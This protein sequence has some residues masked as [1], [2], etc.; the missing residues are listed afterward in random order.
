M[1]HRRDGVQIIG[2]YRLQKAE[3]SDEMKRLNVKQA[4]LYVGGILVCQLSWMGCFPLI[5]AYYTAVCLEDTARGLLSL[6]MLAGI[7]LFVP[8]TAAVKYLMALMVILI[9]VKLFEWAEGRCTVFCGAIAATMATAMTSVAGALLDMRGQTG[10][11]VSVLESLFVFSVIMAG[12]RFINRFLQLSLFPGHLDAG[13]YKEQ[14]LVNYADSFSGLSKVF[15]RMS[16]IRKELSPE[17]VGR[18]QDELTGSLCINCDQCAICWEKEESTM[19]ACLAYM[20]QSLQRTG[21]PDQEMIVQMQERCPY[22]DA[23]IHEAVRIFEKARLN[24]AWYNR[25]VENRE[26]IAQQLDAMAYIMEDC[27]SEIT[28]ITQENRHLIAEVKFRAKERGVM[29]QKAHLYENKAKRWQFTCQARSR[30][31]GCISM[32]ELTRAVSAGLGQGMRPHRDERAM[33]SPQGGGVIFEEDTCF[34]E[35]HAVARRV[36]DGGC[37]SGDNYSFLMMENGQ[38]VMMLSDGMGSGSTASKESE[39]VL[40]LLEKFLEAGFSKETALKMMNSAM[41]IRGEDDLYS[42]VDICS[43]DLYTGVCEIYK[44]GAAATFIRH[45]NYVEH[46]DSCSLPVGVSNRLEIRNTEKQLGDGDFLVMVSDGVLEYL[47]DDETGLEPEEIMCEILKYLS[48]N[49]PSQL[50]DALME[51][52]LSRTGHT[53]GDDMTIL[54]AGIWRK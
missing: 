38:M 4:I 29:I 14:R 51:E 31:N 24:L 25:L 10:V 26:I 13:H 33:I 7:I 44:V 21:E 35:T 12:T 5:P 52:V 49:R 8:L 53:A 11:L 45:K 9:T 39:L 34:H 17:Q 19:S 3:D 40:E 48:Y 22:T 6:A 46:V 41:V 2:V 32:K 37:V 15:Y 20:I 30:T 1:C 54:A 18:I 42:T 28:E 47:Q 50:A 36:K 16:T 23:V 43:L 27:A